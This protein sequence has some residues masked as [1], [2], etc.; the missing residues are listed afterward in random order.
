MNV[1][2]CTLDGEYYLANIFATLPAK[3]LAEKRAALICTECLNPAFF[4]KASRN[5]R[6]ASFGAK[7]HVPGC[8]L[9]SKEAEEVEGALF[10]VVDPLIN[11]GREV[12]LD[13]NPRAQP[14]GHAGQSTFEAKGGKARGRKF[15][16]VGTPG[17]ARSNRRLRG[18]LR[19]LCASSAL[20]SSLQIIDLQ[21][22]GK[23]PF[24]SVLKELS[25]TSV[26]PRAPY[27]F[28]GEILATNENQYRIFLNGAH[29]ALRLDTACMLEVMR[30]NGLKSSSEFKGKKVIA[31]AEC[32]GTWGAKVTEVS[33]IALL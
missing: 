22:Y 6:G 9:A 13:L 4:T 17:A 30:R 8:G 14:T 24:C 7:P 26:V 3:E 12:K 21:D 18:I 23:H 15:T 1:A 25:D 19:E 5:G 33:H 27:L 29:L 20:Q 31:L 2:Q 11:S 10:E 32:S 28:W 16:G